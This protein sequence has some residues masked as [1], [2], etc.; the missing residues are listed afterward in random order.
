MLIRDWMSR[1]VISARPTQTVEEALGLLTNNQIRTLPVIQDG[2][3]VGVVSD[4]DL[5]ANRN[6]PTVILEQIMNR[7]PVTAD[8]NLTVQEAANLLLNNRI[9][10]LPVV[11]QDR[12]PIGVFTQS[13][14]NRFTV[15]VTGLRRG[16]ISWGFLI[17]DRP[18]SIKELTDVMR[19]HGGR[20]ASILTS[21]VGVPRNHRKVFIGVR[22]L[23]RSRL[24]E[25][26]G[27]L[28]QKAPL[29]YRI[30]HRENNRKICEV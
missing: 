25:L 29:L 12:R 26:A 24:S 2:D 11:D 6:S 28:E 4:R 1:P 16:G 10:G 8:H 7:A 9:S 23:D 27:E 20:I 18:G 22:G 19:R 3:L 21:Y 13:D 17:E 15:E 5:R 30:D 14:L